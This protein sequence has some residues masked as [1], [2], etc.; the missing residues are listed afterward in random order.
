MRPHI[1]TVLAVVLFG[2]TLTQGCAIRFGGRPNLP[3]W[4]LIIK[5]NPPGAT[6][7]GQVLIGSDLRRMEVGKTPRELRWAKGSDNEWIHIQLKNK[8]VLVTPIVGQR[9]IFVDF[10]SNPPKVTGAAVHLA[11]K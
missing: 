6:I 2:A 5:S 8:S 1:R 10:A 4:D 7:S 11:P 3:V 9:H